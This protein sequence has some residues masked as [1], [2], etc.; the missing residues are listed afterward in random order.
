MRIPPR[1]HLSP[2]GGAARAAAMA[3]PL[4]PRSLP[5]AARR[6]GCASRLCT[7][8]QHEVDEPSL[9]RL[10]EIQR[11]AK[12]HQKKRFIT[13]P[14]PLASPEGGGQVW[15]GSE[16]PKSR[17]VDVPCLLLPPA[18]LLLTEHCAEG[19]ARVLEVV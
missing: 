12:D 1:G 9:S 17:G 2:H 10:R 14:P 4:G 7:E 16:V 15:P 5:C 6:A 18:S 11:R 3:V 19:L 13:N 8:L